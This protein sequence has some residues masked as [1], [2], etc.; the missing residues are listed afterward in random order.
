[1]YKF[2]KTL[3]LLLAFLLIL[4][5]STYSY[6]GG[7]T[8]TIP[9]N[10]IQKIY[11]ELDGVAVCQLVKADGGYPYSDDIMES[12]MAGSEGQKF[13]GRTKFHEIH[14]ELLT[15]SATPAITDWIS[16]A[17]DQTFDRKDGAIVT[18][19]SFGKVKRRLYFTQAWLSEITFPGVDFASKQNSSLK[20]TLVPESTEMEI[21]AGS[22]ATISGLAPVGAS[23]LAS[24][25]VTFNGE[26]NKLRKI[27]PFTFTAEV[28]EHIIYGSKG[29]EITRLIPGKTEEPDLSVWFSENDIGKYY[30]WYWDFVAEGNGGPSSEKTLG[31][32]YQTTAGVRLF[33]LN[34]SGMGA[35][36]LELVSNGSNTE[37]GIYK[38]QLYSEKITLSR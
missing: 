30:T 16:S 9:A 34:I 32:T 29:R 14:L 27:E 2:K 12:G 15:G 8:R 13:L 24:A 22:V 36:D 25:T 23:W 20:L 5:F 11:L 1:M 6:A 28:I 33:A 38:M 26:T 7:N 18:A 3:T 4:A 17:L 37:S 35:F 31:I 21:G 19:D 10:Q